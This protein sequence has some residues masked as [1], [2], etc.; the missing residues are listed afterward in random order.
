MAKT[1]SFEE[2]Y[3][4][5][6]V[7]RRFNNSTS[8]AM[9][10]SYDKNANTGVRVYRALTHP[11]VAAAIGEIRN[12]DKIEDNTELPLKRD[13]K[14]NEL[15][16]IG[17]GYTFVEN[18]PPLFQYFNDQDGNEISRVV[19][20]VSG[21]IM[22]SDANSVS[23]IVRRTMLFRLTAIDESGQHRYGIPSRKRYWEDLA[24]YFVGEGTRDYSDF[25][26]YVNSLDSIEEKNLEE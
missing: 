2:L 25:V 15:I 3:C 21:V 1:K 20:T 10:I 6:A 24:D 14:T 7:F 26:D 9:Y 4:I 18:V 22:E 17:N 12:P 16:S 11:W 19:D 13:E 23:S 5:K 8:V